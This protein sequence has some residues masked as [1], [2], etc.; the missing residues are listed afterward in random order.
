[1]IRFKKILCPVDFFKTSSLAFDYTLKLADH[2]KAK[3]HAIHV[4]APLTGAAY[5]TPFNMED[6]T[7]DMKKESERFLKGLRSRAAKR[8]AEITTEVAVG[9]I[10]REIL[11]SAAKQKADLVVIGTLGRRGFE[12]LALGSVTEHMMRHC[13][14]PLLTVG[15]GKKA[16]AIPPDIRRILMTTDF[17]TGTTDAVT[18]ALSIAQ[19]CQA[20]LTL[21]HVLNDTAV[22]MAGRYREALR[23]GV[24][25][26]LQRL[27]PQKALDWCKVETRI[28]TGLPYEVIA[29]V[30]RSGAFDLV[31]M[32]IHGK[33]L[34]ERAFV[35]STAER[36]LRTASVSCPVLLIPPKQKR[37]TE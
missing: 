34:L 3:V 18:Y 13:P 7:Q 5:G 32:N 11:R 8:G 35:G 20:T 22:N 31:V 1:M 30:V 16:G 9:D 6:L 4:V 21:L 12:R 14:V 17:S 25:T 33:S 15:L 10:E 28:E 24:E 29:K 19:E 26:E 2:Y 23:S 37:K 36:T 27:V